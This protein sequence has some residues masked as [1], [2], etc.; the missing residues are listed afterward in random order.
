MGETP[1][2][3]SVGIGLPPRFVPRISCMPV[4]GIA[5]RLLTT[6]DRNYA[7]GAHTHEHWVSCYQSVP[8]LVV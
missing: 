6:E 7:G 2:I 8:M 1:N 3:D 4:D 5:G